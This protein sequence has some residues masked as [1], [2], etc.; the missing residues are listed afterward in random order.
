M[1]WAATDEDANAPRPLGGRRPSQSFDH[2][3]TERPDDDGLDDV[4]NAAF[5]NY[6]AVVAALDD[7]RLGRA[8]SLRSWA[9]HAG[10]AASAAS[11]A[12]TGSTWPRMPTVQRLARAVGLWLVLDASPEMSLFAA[13]KDIV[14]PPAAGSNG[15]W[16]SASAAPG[17]RGRPPGVVTVHRL[18]D[19]LHVRPHTLYDLVKADRSP[20]SA[21]VFGLVAVRE[22]VVGVTAVEPAGDEW[23]R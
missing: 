3:L 2:T 21:T 6:R 15:S 22:H 11:T 12:L 4:E 14:D 18:C 1:Y 8:W 7:A 19:E 13:V 5:K 20:S 9:G 17:W 23:G 10:V 16:S